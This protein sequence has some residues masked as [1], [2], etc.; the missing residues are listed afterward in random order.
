LTSFKHKSREQREGHTQP[1]GTRL[2]P[3]A[4]VAVVHNQK[5]VFVPTLGAIVSDGLVTFR[6]WAPA[7][8]RVSVVIENQREV[9]L[10]KDDE[11]YFSAVV[12]EGAADQRYWYRLA[13]GLRPDPASRFQPDGPLGPSVVVDPRSY[14]WRDDKWWGAPVPHEHVIYEMHIGSFTPEGTWH[15]AERHLP[16][17]ADLGIT[18]LE[19]MPIAEFSGRFGWGYDGV[20]LFA[21]FHL[22]GTPDD[23]RRFVDAAHTAGLAVILDVVYNH[24]GPVG[25]FLRDFAPAFF[26]K[27]GEWGD[28]INYDGK[29]AA[30]VRAFVIENAAYWISE[31]HF[32]G[33]R[34][35]ATH[36]IH[37]ESPEHVVSEMCRAARAAAGARRVF[38]VGES[39]SQDTRLLREGGPYSDGLDALWNE[40]WHHAAFV[41]LTGRREAYFTDY[42]GSASEFVSMA[43]HGTLYQGQWYSWQR[44]PRGGYALGLPG[45]SFV[46][47][48]EN[49]DQ[50][51]NTGL[52]LRLY[53]HVDHARWRA[54]TTL[55]LVGPQLPLLF[56]GQEFA[57]QQPFTYFADHEGD[58]AEAVREGRLQ[59]LSQF[60]A[61]AEPE[62]QMLIARPNDSAAYQACK[63]Q[64]NASDTRRTW[65]IKLHRDLLKL[66]RSDPVLARL[67]TRDVAVESAAPTNGLVLIRYISQAGHRLLIVNLSHDVLSSMNDAL[68]APPPTHRWQPM[69]TSEHPDYGGGVPGFVETGRWPIRGGSATILAATRR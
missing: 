23:V 38:L 62:M 52:G 9:P 67:G 32:D 20:N 48:L 65:T 44:Q 55:L 5:S 14:Q 60:P 61:L 34:F 50:V 47:F 27:P 7:Q 25:N 21:P 31:F 28:T 51:A 68:F 36:G 18:T 37:D 22:Y 17:L 64:R 11:G 58:L 59:F 54:L 66:R 49:H 63:L 41:A 43:R 15:A 57:S 12:P 46:C 39:E 56:Q 30:Q 42:E 4:H 26:G 2:A 40:D 16:E 13:E 24:F 6:A 35:D 29:D 19:V 8:K 10:S 53:Q 33:L 1:S 45:A 69:W 3:W